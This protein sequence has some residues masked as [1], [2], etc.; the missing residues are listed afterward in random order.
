MTNNPY[1]AKEITDNFDPE[2]YRVVYFVGDKDMRENPRFQKTSGTTKEGYDWNIEV[3]PHVPIHIPKIGEMSGTSLRKALKDADEKRFDEIMGDFNPEIYEMIKNK[4]SRQELEEAQYQLG[5]FCGIIKQAILEGNN[6]G[7]MFGV[8]GGAYIG[9][10]G[11]TMRPKHAP[12]E[13]FR[14]DLTKEEIE[15]LEEEELN[16]EELEEISVMGA[17]GG[18]DVEMAAGN[19]PVRKNPVKKKKCKKIDEMTY[20]LTN[21]LLKIM[22]EN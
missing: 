19:P 9:A 17:V 10:T 11:N 13:P 14:P 1:Y 20:N 5:V 7:T 18:S 3:A 15:A 16:E 22:G 6:D 8:G 21:Y 12:D 4:L 2:E